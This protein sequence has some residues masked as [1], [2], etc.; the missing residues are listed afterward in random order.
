VRGIV[1]TAVVG[2]FAPVQLAFAWVRTEDVPLVL[3]NL[4]FF[5]E[6]DVCFFRSTGAF[7]LRPKRTQ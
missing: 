5:A 2:Q 6:F 4:N 3:G 1:L 7:E